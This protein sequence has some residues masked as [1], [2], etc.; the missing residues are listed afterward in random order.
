[1]ELGP[2]G[3]DDNLHV[4]Y[5]SVRESFGPLLRATLV[6]EKVSAALGPMY[7]TDPGEKHLAPFIR[8][9]KESGL[10]PE[11]LEGSSLAPSWVLERVKGIRIGRVDGWNMDA[12]DKDWEEAVE[13]TRAGLVLEIASRRGI[14]LSDGLM[15]HVKWKMKGTVTGR[16][17]V[18]AGGYNPLVIARERNEGRGQYALWRSRIVPSGPNRE[19]ATIDFRAMDLC[20]MIAVTPGLAE[21]YQGTTDLHG[22]TAEIVGIDRDVAKIELFIHAYGGRSKYAKEFEARLPELR[23]IHGSSKEEASANACLV[24]KTSARAFRAA[25]SKA[26]PLLTGEDIR[27]MFTVH[28]ELTLDVLRGHKDG[29]SLVTKALEEGASERIGVPYTVG[30][31]IGRNY[32]EAKA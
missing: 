2:F 18:E 10:D 12:L 30:M 27:P 14:H 19:I 23:W 4:V 9:A 31:S 7:D 17:G 26:L 8:S 6:G 32:A 13:W 5:H 15:A 11:W 20:S 16:F 29:L 28:D 24:Q 21:K 3:F 25:L 1:M 22:R